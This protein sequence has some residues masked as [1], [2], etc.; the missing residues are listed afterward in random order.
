MISLTLLGG[1]A[2]ASEIDDFAKLEAIYQSALTDNA[3]ALAQAQVFAAGIKPDTSYAVRVELLKTRL[4]LAI[5]AGQARLVEADIAELLKLGNQQRDPASM[6]LANIWIARQETEADRPELALATLMQ[7]KSLADKSANPFVLMFFNRTLGNVYSKLGQFEKAMQHQLMALRLAEQQPRR[8]AHAKLEQFNRLGAL[9]FA[10]KEP[11]KALVSF[12]AALKLAPAVG[13]ETTLASIKVNQGNALAES[14]RGREAL[15]AYQEALAISRTAGLVE[16]EIVVL[17]DLADHY[18]RSRSYDRAADFARQALLKA[19]EINSQSSMTVAR[20]NLGLALSGQGKIKEGAQH[21]NAALS[22]YHQTGAKADEEGLVAELSLMY[23]RAGLL[24]E[25]L[26]A[27]RQQYQLDQ[28]LFSADQS[29]AISSLQEQFN[30]EQ[31]QKEIDLLAKENQLKSTELVNGRLQL[32][33]SLLAAALTLLAAVFIGLLYRRV[34]RTNEKLEAVNSQLEFH[35]TRDPLTGLYN[36]R[37]FLDLMKQR[38]GPGDG[39]REGDVAIAAGMMLLDVD[40]FKQVN[41][42]WG[43]AVGDAVLV[44]VARRLKSTVRDSDMVLRWGG[45][46]FLVYSPQANTQQLKRLAER[47]LQAI[48]AQP[49]LVAGQSIPIT[50]TGG[51]IALPYAGISEALCN[52]E[53]ALQIADMALYLGKAHGRNR[54]Y[55]LGPLLAPPEV[56]LP[57]L[58]H[59]LSAALKA[60]MVELIEVMGPAPAN[61]G[62]DS[63]TSGISSKKISAEA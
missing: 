49:I 53:K 4:P 52:W 5:E 42:V 38:P 55:G 32:A 2:A 60:G 56:A 17:I 1:G 18:L 41:D 57:L 22:S 12:E 61:L 35:S 39:R 47:L 13:S 45:E 46:E 10:M 25:A 11:Q 33:V 16:T 9:Y 28:E 50:L 8:Q 59:D 54:V 26:A 34:R 36:R 27:A 7:A 31:R 58:D 48:G 51:F 15:A 3:R 63:H 30:A 21:I 19:G 6:A 23:E 44:E 14:G 37:S 20:A 43:H 40:L 24:R 62:L 29:R